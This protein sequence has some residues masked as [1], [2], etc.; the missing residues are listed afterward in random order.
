MQGCR[1]TSWDPLFIMRFISSL[2]VSFVLFRNLLLHWCFLFSNFSLW[3]SC[4]S[5]CNPSLGK[6]FCCLY[7]CLWLTSLLV[8]YIFTLSWKISG[9]RA[10][11]LTTDNSTRI[12]R[13]RVIVCSLD[14]ELLWFWCWTL[15]S[16]ML[17][18][19]T[20]DCGHLRK[21]GLISEIETLIWTLS[22][23]QTVMRHPIYWFFYRL[24]FFGL[25]YY[26]DDCRLFG[27]IVT[28]RRP[29]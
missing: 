20:F 15:A 6:Q 16:K 7:P 13:D 21:L 4:S 2:I 18:T 26:F 27:L 24:L 17:W 9:F 1:A 12:C 8:G 22:M 19:T 29:L 14:T 11:R 25:L 10:W 23:R 3:I 28:H 5:F